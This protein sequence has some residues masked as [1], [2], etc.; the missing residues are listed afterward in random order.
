[1]ALLISAAGAQAEKWTIPGI[2]TFTAPSS[3]LYAVEAI[4]A[5]GGDATGEGFSPAGGG[6]AV[7]GD[8]FLSS[9]AS[10]VVRVGGHGQ[11]APFYGCGGGGA[12]NYIGGAGE[13]GQVGANGV[14]DQGSKV[15]QGLKGGAGGANG[16]GGGGNDDG[17]GADGFLGGGRFIGG[18]SNGG[19]GWL[20]KSA[21][22][23]ASSTESWVGGAGGADGGFQGATAALAAAAPLRQG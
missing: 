11:T 13:N 17:P 5:S 18:G 16:S 1:L 3:G 8:V 22:S 21:K 4:G 12:I 10:I 23:G 15:G 19:E 2:Y 14:P 6:A 20:G 7:M 9:G